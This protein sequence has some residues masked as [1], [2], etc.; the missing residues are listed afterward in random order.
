MTKG[1]GNGG[2]SGNQPKALPLQGPSAPHEHTLD[3]GQ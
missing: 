3:Q 1:Y 2:G